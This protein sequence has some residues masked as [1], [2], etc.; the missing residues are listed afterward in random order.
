MRLDVFLDRLQ[1]RSVR[2][3]TRG[4]VL[5]V[6]EDSRDVDWQSVFV[7]V[8]GAQ[9]D[10]HKYA[11]GLDC[12]LV[13]AE[14]DVE[15]AEGVPVAIVKD[16]RLALAEAA[17]IL[18]GDPSHEVSVVGITGT[19]GKTTTSWI[20]ESILKAAGRKVGV[21]GTTGHRANH[22]EVGS[23]YTTPPAPQ[24]QGLLRQMV[25]QGCEFVTAEVSSIALASYR[26]H[27]S[28]FEVGVFT[29]LTRDHLDFHGSMESYMAAKAMLFDAYLAQGAHAV[30]PRVCPELDAVLENR[31]D[32]RVW[33]YGIEGGDVFTWEHS[34]G[35]DGTQGRVGSPGGSFVFEFPLLGEHNLK[36]ALAAVACSLALGVSVDAI[37]RGLAQLPVVPGRMEVVPN[38][39]GITVLVDYAHTPDALEKALEGLRPLTTSDLVV[40]F[41]C[42]GDRDRGKRPEMGRV[43]TATADRVYATSDNPRSE[44]PADILREVAAGLSD[45]ARII[46]DRKEAIESAI[47]EAQP[48]DVILIAGKG[49]EQYQEIGGI[50]HSFDDRLIAAQ[51]LGA[52]P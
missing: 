47:R 24:W 12:A 52:S 4:V 39:V 27:G 18:E 19:N 35:A 31:K 10:G 50:Q 46:V 15:P 43:A 21:I 51:A 1:T 44:D 36:N 34:L 42:G 13:I 26:V 23:G 40:V 29:N 3:D 7:A 9:V 25:D 45:G 48:G 41:G 16:T 5:R 49:H 11:K 28:R 6:T 14:D 22:Q 30:V 37:Q 32:L 33:R 2:G 20:L 17:S 38:Q 8:R